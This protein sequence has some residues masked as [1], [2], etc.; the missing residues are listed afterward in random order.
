MSTIT[1][2]CVSIFVFLKEESGVRTYAPQ[3]D[4][5]LVRTKFTEEAIMYHYPPAKHKIQRT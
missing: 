2:K 1:T 3:L 4:R 5:T